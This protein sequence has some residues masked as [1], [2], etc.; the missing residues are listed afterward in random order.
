MPNHGT[1]LKNLGAPVPTRRTRSASV[2]AASD[3]LRTVL[4]ERWALGGARFDLCDRRGVPAA[5][6]A[7]D[8]ERQTTSELPL[9]RVPYYLETN[10]PGVFGVGDVRHGSVKRYASAVGKGAMSIPP[11]PRW[12]LGA[13][14]PSRHT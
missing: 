9:T 5:A 7:E 8:G 6:V 14:E 11:I 13:R 12:P 4:I 3:G 10:I 1:E 2:Y